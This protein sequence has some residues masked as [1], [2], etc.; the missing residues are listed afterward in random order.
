MVMI[1]LGLTNVN[2]LL[3]LLFFCKKTIL[4]FTKKILNYGFYTPGIRIRL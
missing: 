3:L 2:F 1:E 4:S